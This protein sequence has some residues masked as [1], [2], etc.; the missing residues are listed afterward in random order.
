MTSSAGDVALVVSAIIARTG[1]QDYGDH[2]EL[3]LEEEVFDA[4][5]MASFEGVALTE[6]HGA[7]IAND[8]D[9]D[10]FAVGYVRNVRREG[11]YLAADL[12]IFDPAIIARV[13]DQDLVEISAGY[14]VDLEKAPDEYS[15][16][17]QRNIRANHVGLGPRGWARCGSACS[18]G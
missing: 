3:R 17:T 13:R 8:D 11:D 9:F 18:V 14:S 16:R 4:E 2:T 6:G 12:V 5:S 10:K 7:W 1:V 15:A